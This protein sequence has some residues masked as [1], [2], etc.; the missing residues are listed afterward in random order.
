MTVWRLESAATLG[1][2]DGLTG[3]CGGVD[4]ID[5]LHQAQRLL[6]GVE[7]RFF[8]GDGVDEI[9]G[10]RAAAH[11]FTGGRDDA[12]IDAVAV[13]LHVELAGIDSRFIDTIDAEQ[14]LDLATGFGALEYDAHF[15]A[16]DHFRPRDLQAQHLTGLERNESVR[17]IFHIGHTTHAVG[18][19]PGAFELFVLNEVGKGL[20]QHVFRLG[21]AHEI[22]RQIDHVQQVDEWT[23][24]GKLLGREP[25]TEA[26]NASA[27]DP[28]RLRGVD[29]AD[30]AILDVAHHR[31]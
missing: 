12:A 27:A 7:R 16:L 30:V 19:A 26:R 3:L 24:S 11:V 17:G 23:T 31:L 21:V 10:T 18:N 6:G 9:R 1:H 29:R 5:H 14:T 22:H 4:G 25:T 2:A 15:L 13:F 28:F 20:T 8:A